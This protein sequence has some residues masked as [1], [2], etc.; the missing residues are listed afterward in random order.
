MQADVH[1]ETHKETFMATL[2][3]IAQDWRQCKCQ[4][5]VKWRNKLII[6]ANGILY[7]CEKNELLHNKVEPHKLLNERS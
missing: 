7:S 6:V 3:I 4:S 2:F 5:V 1:Q